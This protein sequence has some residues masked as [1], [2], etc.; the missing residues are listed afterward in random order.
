MAEQ[1]RDTHFQPKSDPYF[2][3]GVRFVDGVAELEETPEHLVE[4]FNATG[5][6]RMLPPEPEEETEAPGTPD[7]V[8]TAPETAPEDFEAVEPQEEATKPPRTTRKK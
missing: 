3:R 6:V 2:I 8:E 1:W 4:Y 5:V 7:P